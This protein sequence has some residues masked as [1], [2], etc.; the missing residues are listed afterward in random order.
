[1]I[2]FGVIALAVGPVV[3]QYSQ[4]ESW[5][6]N[7]A[8]PPT[9]AAF[10]RFWQ[11]DFRL[12]AAAFSCLAKFSIALSLV[13]NFSVLFISIISGGSTY[14]R[15]LFTKVHQR[16]RRKG[17]CGELKR[18]SGR[19]I[20]VHKLQPLRALSSYPTYFQGTQTPPRHL[21]THKIRIYLHNTPI[22]AGPDYYPLFAPSS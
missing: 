4:Q 15:N 11:R 1:M 13:E 5:Q 12:G 8:T 6:H 2:L 20:G 19:L 10:D 16:C 21:L 18:Y 22:F 9:L 7:F 3:L 17:I 14:I